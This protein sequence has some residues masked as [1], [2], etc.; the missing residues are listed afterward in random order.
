V[1]FGGQLIDVNSDLVL[2]EKM[3]LDRNVV[4]HSVLH[5]IS[6]L[7][8]NSINIFGEETKYDIIRDSIHSLVDV[9]LVFWLVI[10][11]L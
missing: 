2:K 8:K 7:N 3:A 5:S 1:L 9:N 6:K 10:V 11:V 4:D